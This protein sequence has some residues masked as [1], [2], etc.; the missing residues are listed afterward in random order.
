[1]TDRVVAD[2]V[3]RPDLTSLAA[4]AA[5]RLVAASGIDVLELVRNPALAATIDALIQAEKVAHVVRPPMM[6]RPV[7]PVHAHDGGR[8]PAIVLLN[9]WTLSGLVWPQQLV[10]TLEQTHRVVRVDNRGTGW[11]R[12]ARR[13][14]TIGD[15]AADVRRV[16]DGLGLEAPTVVGLSMGGMIAQE[17]AIRWPDRVG[18]LVLLATRPPNPE[19]TLPPTAVLAAMLAT[20]PEGVSLRHFLRDGWAA[21][22]APGFPAAHPDVVDEVGAEIARRPTPRLALL[23]QA[24]A[25]AAWSGVQ[26][27]ALVTAPT[28]VVHGTED[29]LVPVRNGMRVAQ[30]IPG[31]RYVEL[32]DV[33]HLVPY[34][35]PDAVEEIVVGAGVDTRQ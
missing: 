27:L 8:G 35:A 19:A 31:A 29:P 5:A 22:T 18:R 11:S 21:V 32:A 12:D 9:G 7:E 17:L 10:E 1:V 20:P 2:R 3:Q 6:C 26:R 13:P 16:I 25:I 30:L 4:A 24:R 33:G 28:T 23:D 34:E 14:F 15:L